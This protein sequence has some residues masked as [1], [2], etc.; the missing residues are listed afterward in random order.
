MVGRAT[1]GVRLASLD[2]GTLV[3]FDLVREENIEDA[4]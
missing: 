2:G 3:G 1:Q 4:E